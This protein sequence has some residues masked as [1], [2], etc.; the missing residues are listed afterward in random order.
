MLCLD[1]LAEVAEH[2]GDFGWGGAEGFEKGDVDACP[3]Q[4][5]EE[6]GDEADYYAC[7]ADCWEGHCKLAVCASNEV[8]SGGVC[9]SGS[10]QSIGSKLGFASE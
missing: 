7:C 3:G 2:D 4:E 1:F 5:G 6:E 8:V 10:A 9:P